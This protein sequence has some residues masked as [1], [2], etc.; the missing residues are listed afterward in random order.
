MSN[1]RR[2]DEE[3]RVRFRNDRFFMDEG[4]WYFETREGQ[5]EGPYQT[6]AMAESKLGDYVRIVG[7]GMLPSDIKL[8]V[9]D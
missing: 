2:G 4:S 6:R 9:D 3:E 8:D 1:K 7:S 5:I